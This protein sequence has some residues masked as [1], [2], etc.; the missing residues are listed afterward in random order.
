MLTLPFQRRSSR[1]I[2]LSHVVRRSALSSLTLHTGIGNRKNIEHSIS[3]PLS[4]PNSITTSY[5]TSSSRDSIET[6][7]FQSSLLESVT[8]E[9][10]R[11]LA[12]HLISRLT[13]PQIERM[14]QSF[15]NGRNRPN[16]QSKA[17]ALKA[18][19]VWLNT[20]LERLFKYPETPFYPVVIPPEKGLLEAINELS[21]ALRS[22]N[23][24]KN[25]DFFTSLADGFDKKEEISNV[26]I[27]STS[28]L[29]NFGVER[30]EEGTR[31]DEIEKFISEHCDKTPVVTIKK[32]ASI[33]NEFVTEEFNE[34]RFKKEIKN[35]STIHHG[36][37]VGIIN[38]LGLKYNIT[39]TENT[40][41]ALRAKNMMIDETVK[42]L[43]FIQ[44]RMLEKR[45]RQENK[46]I[47]AEKKRKKEKNSGTTEVNLEKVP[48]E[49]KSRETKKNSIAPEVNLEK[50]NEERKSIV[51]AAA[52]VGLLNVGLPEGLI[53]TGASDILDDLE[54]QT[55]VSSRI[56]MYAYVY[57]IQIVESH[58]F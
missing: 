37:T 50:L 25:S 43:E 45:I 53:Y 14:T 58:K 6:D 3:S 4:F 15:I 55:E 34:T 9:N 30:K 35:I 46:A 31:D 10:T 56:Y 47:K 33:V 8:V 41:I 11:D 29:A 7:N 52:E 49:R 13:E 1:C 22:A 27:N 54:A 17:V 42:D 20:W 12:D 38:F 57:T 36:F 19:I 28:P 23:K 21:I 26:N 51:T 44:Q 5:A 18:D 40:K 32:L 48:E 24:H 39:S 2:V 16:R